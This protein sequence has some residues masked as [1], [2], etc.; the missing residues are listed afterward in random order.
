MPKFKA[1]RPFKYRG[2]IRAAGDEFDVGDADVRAI[3]KAF[4]AV[5]VAEKKPARRVVSTRA[6]KAEEPEPAPEPK[7]EAVHSEPVEPMTTDDAPAIAPKRAYTRR[8]MK[9]ED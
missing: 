7:A 3:V 2:V 9:A 5:P 6:L 8:D 4:G 1:T